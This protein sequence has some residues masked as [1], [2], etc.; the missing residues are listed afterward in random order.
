MRLLSY[1]DA[2]TERLGWVEGGRAVPVAEAGGD[3][4]PRTMADLVA[5]GP[6]ALAALQA[7]APGLAAAAAGGRPVEALELLAPLPR[8]GKVVAVGL[9]YVGHATE[10]NKQ[11]PSEPLVFAKLPSAVVGHGAEITWD[12]A[13]ARK[14]DAEAELAVVI[15][16]RARHVRVADAL[17][18][19]LGYTACNDVSARDLQAADGQWL[20]AKSLDTFCPMGPVLVTADEIPDPSG[21]KIECIINGAT[22]QSAS[23]ADMHFSVRHLISWCS[24]SFTLEPG[25]VIA[26]GTPPGVGIYRDP[27]Q[28]LSDGDEV[29]VEI[30]RIGRLANRCRYRAAPPA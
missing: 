19:V 3:Q 14:V 12:P 22:T 23:T 10:Q 11:P 29:V 5:G 7:A 27:P 13:L 20:R 26:T 18:H 28:L 24:A 1:M 9:N 15:G 21:L 6:A 4:L 17:D 25:D 16:R 2:G 8:P 30:E